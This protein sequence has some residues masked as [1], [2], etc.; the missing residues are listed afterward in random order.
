[1]LPFREGRV[2][3]AIGRMQSRLR[4]ERI[5]ED[6]EPSAREIAFAFEDGH[7]RLIAAGL[8]AE[9]FHQVFDVL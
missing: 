4:I 9:D 8:Y 7:G 3:A 2:D 6:P 1:M 5:P